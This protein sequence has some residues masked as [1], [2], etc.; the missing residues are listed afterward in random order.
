MFK[1]LA[2]NS[3]SSITLDWKKPVIDEDSIED[4]EKEIGRLIG[5]SVTVLHFRRMEDPV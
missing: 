1:I 5:G 2:F 3:I 4:L